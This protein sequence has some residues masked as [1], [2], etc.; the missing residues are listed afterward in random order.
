MSVL[1]NICAGYSVLCAVAVCSVQCAHFVLLSLK[2]DHVQCV[3]TEMFVQCV[4]T[5]SAL[6]LQTDIVVCKD[7]SVRHCFVCK[8]SSDRHCFVCVQTDW[9]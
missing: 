8:D 9:P 4:Q 6:C 1:C 3:Q 7:I 5:Y 2:T